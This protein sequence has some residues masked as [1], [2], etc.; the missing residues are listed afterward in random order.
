LHR[1]LAR[2]WGHC[3]STGLKTQRL[4]AILCLGPYDTP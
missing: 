3:D 1:L 2:A 4:S